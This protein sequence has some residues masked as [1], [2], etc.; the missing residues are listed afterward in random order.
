MILSSYKAKNDILHILV[1]MRRKI[2][3]YKIEN[4]NIFMY[5]VKYLIMTILLVTENEKFFL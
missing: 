3:S 5:T 4:D 2:S 1:K